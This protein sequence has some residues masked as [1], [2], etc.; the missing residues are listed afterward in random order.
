VVGK[1]PSSLFLPRVPSVFS[2]VGDFKAARAIG[3]SVSGALVLC[4]LAESLVPIGYWSVRLPKRVPS[5]YRPTPEWQTPDQP[6][7]CLAFGRG[8][9]AKRRA[10]RHA[11][12]GRGLI[13]VIYL[14][15]SKVALDSKSSDEKTQ[16]SMRYCMYV[17]A[18]N[19]AKK[20]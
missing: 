9:Q 14:G 20:L 18:Q 12:H 6:G 13:L 7:L 1:A 11:D 10:D 16:G 4:S 19:T 8:F 17:R 3:Q 2:I 5:W 15:S